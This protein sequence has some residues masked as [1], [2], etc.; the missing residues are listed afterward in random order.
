MKTIDDSQV[1]KLLEDIASIKSV[2]TEN[3][4]LL[5]HLL[6]PVH[7][8][9]LTLLAGLAVIGISALYY[10]L[11]QRYGSYADIPQVL[12][13]GSLVFVL[14]LYLV[15]VVLKRILWIKSLK[16]MGSDITFGRLVKSLYSYQLLHVWLPIMVM[17]AFL[18]VYLCW[19]DV[20]R[21]IVSVVGIALGIIY[22]SIGGIARIKQYMVTGYWFLVTA[23]GPFLFPQVSAWI[24]LAV[25][26]G[27]AMLLFFMISGNSQHWKE[28]D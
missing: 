22:N 8:R 7:F 14:I 19:M 27:G 21:Y 17:A 28:E 23:L 2:L 11:L 26:S 15:L 1:D 25:S 10:F 12:R 6:L 5:K 9:L 13:M 16:R 24:L 4:P 18:I 20:E 3:K